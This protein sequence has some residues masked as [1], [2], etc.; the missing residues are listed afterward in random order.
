MIEYLLIEAEDFPP[1]TDVAGLVFKL[2]IF[3]N[4]DFTLL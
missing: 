1:Y 4:E 2:A 3:D